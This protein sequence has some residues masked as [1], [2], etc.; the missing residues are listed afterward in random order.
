MYADDV[1][2][3]KELKRIHNLGNLFA[4]FKFEKQEKKHKDPNGEIIDEFKTI[5]NSE[6]VGTKW[7]PLSYMAVR[8]KL[9]AIAKDTH[10]LQRFLSECK[11]YQ[12]RNGSFSKR[13]FGSLK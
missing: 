12:K 9:E 10:E 4:N 3:E 6:R 7:K 13:F 5:I 11:D 1:R 2:Y 8:K